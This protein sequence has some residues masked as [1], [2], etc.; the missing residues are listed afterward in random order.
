MATL[1]AMKARIARETT[2]DD[3]LDNGAIAEEI[4]SAINFYRAERFWFN[5]KRTQLV[6][7]TVVGQTDYGAATAADI[8]H[9]LRIDYVTASWPGDGAITVGYC[10]PLDMEILLSNPPLSAARPY[11]YSYYEQT[12]RLYP[13][14]DRIYPVRVAGVF[15]VNPP[16]TDVEAG[17]P[18]MTEAE[19][20]IRSRAKRNLY[21]NSMIGTEAAQGTAMRALEEEA[22]SRL[23]R[24]TSSRTQVR[25]IRPA[26]L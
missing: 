4:T 7:N 15:R 2:R 3:L 24:E 6:F 26:C 13:E 19:E 17:N 18:W 23:K 22:L 9:I 11:R 16:A 12:L 21:M 10:S 8:A 1:G 5:E 14:P 20:L 25:H